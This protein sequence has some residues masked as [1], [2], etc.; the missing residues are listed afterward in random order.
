[1]DRVVS[2]RLTDETI[3]LGIPEGC[4]PAGSG[5]R[6]VSER[7][8]TKGERDRPVNKDVPALPLGLM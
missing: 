1:V 4:T 7:G 5:V 2:E 6:A 8:Q 3:R